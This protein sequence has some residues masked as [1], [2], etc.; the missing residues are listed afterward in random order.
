ME[1]K[2]YVMTIRLSL[3]LGMTLLMLLAL[4]YELTGN[5]AHEGIGIAIIVLFGIHNVLNKR[6]YGSLLQ[7][8]ALRRS[9]SAVV[10]VLLVVFVVVLTASSVMHSRSFFAFLPVEKSLETRQLHTTA[11]YW[12]LILISLHI[13]M[14]WEMVMAAVRKAFGLRKASR[15]RDG[16]L[17]LLAALI[18]GHGVLFSLQRNLGAKLT[19]CYSFDYWDFEASVADFFIGYACVMGLCICITHSLSKVFRQRSRPPAQSVRAVFASPDK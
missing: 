18:A 4:A 5:H 17:R 6:W 10:N 11:A 9:P 15:W 14:H 8:P 1:F 16:I 3:D 19:G 12:G 13:G 7:K 2:E